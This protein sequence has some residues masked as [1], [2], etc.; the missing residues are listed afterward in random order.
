MR[1]CKQTLYRF[2]CQGFI[3]LGSASLLGRAKILSSLD[4]YGTLSVPWDLLH[5]GW[6]KV[7]MVQGESECCTWLEPPT[8]VQYVVHK[9]C[10]TLTIPAY[11]YMGNFSSALVEGKI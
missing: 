3:N 5:E 2:E 10:C 4:Y 11:M 8:P 6:V 9:T 7:C 1:A